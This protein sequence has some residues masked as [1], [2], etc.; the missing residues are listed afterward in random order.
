[1]RQNKNTRFYIGGSGLDQTD[2]FQKF[3]GSG[4]DR[5][6]FNRIR[7]GL[8]LKNFTVRSSLMHTSALQCSS[9]AG[10]TSSMFQIRGFPYSSR[11]TGCWLEQGLIHRAFKNIYTVIDLFLLMSHLIYRNNNKEPSCKQLPNFQWRLEYMKTRWQN[12]WL[13]VKTKKK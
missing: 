3:C 13:N 7:T 10:R 11:L 12:S 1:M 2:D 6:Q 4:L 9:L 8:G 5:I